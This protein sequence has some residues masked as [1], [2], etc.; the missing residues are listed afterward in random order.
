MNERARHPVKA[1]EK[2]VEIIEVLK[3]RRSAYLREIAAELDMN[4]STVHNHLATL[5]EQEYVIKDGDA[6]ELSLQFLNIGGVLR[7]EIDLFEAAK[8]EIDEL[9][10]SSGELVTLVTHE[11][12]FG[13]VLYRAKGE[14]AVELDT[15]IGAQVPLHNSAFGK[16]MLAHLPSDRINA[17]FEARGLPP[18]TPNTITDEDEIRAELERIEEQGFAYDDEERW[19]GLRCVAAPIRTED[20]TVKGAVSISTPKSRM[21]DDAAREEHVD[22]VKNTANLVELSLTYS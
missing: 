14:N 15:H 22:A 21:A 3:E 9:A 1:L 10:A 16:A 11:R 8:P 7:N 12:G 17:V 4:K 19:R 2:S 18:E 6:Y 5:R 20:G 13:V